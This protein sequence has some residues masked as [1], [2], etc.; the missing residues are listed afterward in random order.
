MV[1]GPFLH[2]LLKKKRIDLGKSPLAEFQL[3]FDQVLRALLTSLE[4]RMKPRFRGAVPAGN[5]PWVFSAKDPVNQQLDQPSGLADAATG[6]G[7]LEKKVK[8]LKKK[9]AEISK[10]EAR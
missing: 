8:A 2:G 4:G 10:L 3:P 9:L 1:D 5:C 6:T 7:V